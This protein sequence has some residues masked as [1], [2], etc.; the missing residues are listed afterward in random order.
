[1]AKILT[2][3][4]LIF[5]CAACSQTFAEQNKN[6]N[7]D[8]QR[9]AE[10]FQGK[11]GKEQTLVTLEEILKRVL[12]NNPEIL[13]KKKMLETAAG[14]KII[15]QSRIWPDASTSLIAGRY[16]ERN[17]DLAKNFAIFAGR[18]QQ[19]L[20]EAGI[21]AS[22]RSGDIVVTIAEQELQAITSLKLHETR[23]T[24]YQALFYRGLIL[25]NRQLKK[26]LEA[27]LSNEKQ[28][29]KSGLSARGNVIRAQI[30]S[31]NYVPDTVEAEKNYREALLQL[32]ALMGVDL[33]PKLSESLFPQGILDYQP[34]QLDLKEES[35]AALQNR[36]DLKLLRSLIAKTSEQKKITEETYYPLV[37]A[38]WDGEF[39]PENALKNKTSNS[40]RPGEDTRTSEMRVGS[41]MTWR[42]VDNGQTAGGAMS[43]QKKKE[44]YEITLKKLEENI[45]RDLTRVSNSLKAEEARI[46][47]LQKAVNVAEENLKN[48]EAQIAVGASGQLDFLNAQSAFYETKFGILKGLYQYNLALAEWDRV[49][50]RYLQYHQQEVHKNR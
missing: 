43:V 8:L 10:E 11:P 15:F 45:P 1:M 38:F 40:P 33:G 23:I 6:P 47:A 5:F 14:E 49:T 9:I 18:I 21:P 37:N 26:R 28:R 50:G 27:N 32:H 4:L 19:P 24:Y 30:Q 20:F 22:L 31:L 35:V 29:Q 41:T 48:V 12:N 3:F 13:Q 42:V 7:A 39:L 34:I 17:Q 25:L 44:N 16:G 36:A 46:N 2:T